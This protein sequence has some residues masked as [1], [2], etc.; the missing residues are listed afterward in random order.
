MIATLFVL[1]A[2]SP[3]GGGAPRESWC[4][5]PGWETSHFLEQTIGLSFEKHKD[6][7]GG[8][9]ARFLQSGMEH[10]LAVCPTN[11]TVLYATLRAQELTHSDHTPSKD[12]LAKAIAALPDSVR[13]ATIRARAVGSVEAAETAVRLDPKYLPAQIALAAAYEHAGDHTSALRLLRSLRALGSVAGGPLLLAKIA[14]AVNDWRLAADSARREPNREGPLCEPVSGMLL[15]GQA[16][17]VEADALLRLGETSRALSALLDAASWGQHEDVDERLRSASPEMIRAMRREADRPDTDRVLRGDLLCYLA[18]ARLKAGDARGGARLLVEA[19]IL[20]T[21]V[22]VRRTA[23]EGGPPLRNEL[24][25]LR[26]KRLT[27]QE[28]DAVDILWRA[29]ND[30]FL[31]PHAPRSNGEQ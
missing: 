24:T 9:A 6:A 5:A 11:E 12:L 29:I 23:L 20:D 7:P 25:K 16:R 15:V 1:A 26:A 14:F 18:V 2:L 27:T 21:R 19:V 31:S 17:M 10:W 3:D 4:P 13:I 22:D 30:G 28:R 8:K